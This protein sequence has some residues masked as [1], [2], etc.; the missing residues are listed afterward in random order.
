[1]EI[2]GIYSENVVLPTEN[3]PIPAC[4]LIKEDKIIKIMKFCSFE[5]A[6]RLTG[7]H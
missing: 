1:M 3:E 4:I 2:H 5:S 7:G 6:R